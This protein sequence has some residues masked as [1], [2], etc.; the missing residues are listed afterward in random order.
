MKTRSLAGTLVLVFLTLGMGTTADAVTVDIQI[1]NHLNSDRPYGTTVTG[2]GFVSSFL[3]HRIDRAPGEDFGNADQVVGGSSYLSPFFIG[4]EYYSNDNSS[5]FTDVNNISYYRYYNY[6]YYETQ[7]QASISQFAGLD[8]ASAT[9]SFDFNR[10]YD[11]YGDDVNLVFSSFDS[12]GT[13]GYW[14]TGQ[15]VGNPPAGSLGS[16]YLSFPQTDF[17]RH[18]IDVT[19]LLQ[20]RIDGGEDYFA[21]LLET[22]SASSR[23]YAYYT[24]PSAANVVLTVEYTELIPEPATMIM[25]GCLGA[26]MVAARK[27]RRKKTD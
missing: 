4:Y 21:M 5:W 18:S 14:N 12:N 6:Y 10:Q 1:G 19:S 25:L 17:S 22:T 15:W 27:A 13:L 11:A 23:E 3:H 9:L 20:D 16:V 8:I 26:G 24:P 2:T 7:M